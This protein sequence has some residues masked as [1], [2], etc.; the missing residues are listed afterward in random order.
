MSAAPARRCRTGS[1]PSSTAACSCCASRT[2]TPPATGP[3][4]PR[5]SSPRW[6]GSASSAAATRARTSSRRTPASTAAAA[7][8]LHAAGRA[9]YCD[10]T[11][12]DVQART[13]DA[14]PGLRRLLPRPRPAGRA[15]AAR[16]AS[17]PPTRA[18]T[19]VVDLIRGEPTFENKLIEDFVIARGDGSPV[20]LLAN[21]VDDMTMGITHVIRAEEHLPN[22]PKQQ[23]LW[24]ALGRH[25]ADLGA[26]AGGGQREAAEALQA[27]RQGGAGG[28][29][30]RGLPGRR[31]AQLPDA[32]RLGAV[33]ATGRSC[34]WSVIEDEFRLEEVNPS[35]AFFDEKKLRAFNG[36]YIRAL[37][38]RG[39]RRGLP[40]VADRHRHHRAAAVGA[41][42]V[43]PGRVRRRGA[44]GADPH[45]ACC[46]RS[47]R[48]STS[49]SWTRR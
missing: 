3:S 49:S 34:P 13:G 18:T 41:G 7:A 30:R 8:R 16:C 9:Y 6:T 24:E 1:T 46:R 28:V 10:C 44:A 4:G 15:R 21:V 29:P 27:P 5:A 19:V 35:P 14:V 31:D 20:F 12:D 43:R 11:R 40:A 22:T 45:R 37:P 26:R 17:V 25:A 39:V 32:A 38:R 2:P 42:G 23:L 47:C 33:A 48:T 36:E